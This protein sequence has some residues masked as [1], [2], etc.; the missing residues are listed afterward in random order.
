MTAEELFEVLQGLQ[1]ST[2]GAVTQ[3]AVAPATA[4]RFG[5]E[6][7]AFI[8]KTHFN[9]FPELIGVPL[10]VNREVPGNAIWFRIGGQWLSLVVTAPWLRKELDGPLEVI[11]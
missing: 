1:Y 7:L 5:Q 3:I 2:K 10:R 9:P 4:A 11:P 6:H 8:S